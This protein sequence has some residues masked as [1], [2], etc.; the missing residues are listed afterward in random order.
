MLLRDAS[1][2][3]HTRTRKGPSPGLTG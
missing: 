1:L 2:D 3:G